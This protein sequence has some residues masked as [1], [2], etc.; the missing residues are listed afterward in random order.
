MAAG[1]A[2]TVR[3]AWGMVAPDQLRKFVRH[4]VRVVELFLVFTSA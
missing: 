2:V 4:W 3:R 1:V